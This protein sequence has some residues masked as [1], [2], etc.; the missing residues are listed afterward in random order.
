MVVKTAHIDSRKYKR[1]LKEELNKFN[2]QSKLMVIGIIE[3][4][5]KRIENSNDKIRKHLS[6]Q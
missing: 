2:A 4:K 5:N 6:K 1:T 3:G